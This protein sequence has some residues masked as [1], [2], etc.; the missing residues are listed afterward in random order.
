MLVNTLIRDTVS[1]THITKFTGD[2]KPSD[3]ASIV[4]AFLASGGIS[5]RDNEDILTQDQLKAMLGKIVKEYRLTAYDES[6]FLQ[7]IRNNESIRTVDFINQTVDILIRHG[8]TG[9]EFMD[10]IQYANIQDSISISHHKSMSA[11][12]KSSEKLDAFDITKFGVTTNMIDSSVVGDYVRP[13][14]SITTRDP[15][16][17]I[18]ANKSSIEGVINPIDRLIDGIDIANLGDVKIRP[19]DIVS[20]RDSVRFIYPD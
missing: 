15:V 10:M 5:I 14:I 13:V 9:T 17:V 3:E 16:G 20:L 18:D 6:R 7:I 12:I 4:D 19:S 2:I 1:S 11:N 8:I